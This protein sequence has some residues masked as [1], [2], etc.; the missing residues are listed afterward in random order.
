MLYVN[1][2]LMRLYA[3][4]W[5]VTRQ[6]IYERVCVETAAWVMREMQSPEGGYYSSLDADSEGHEGKF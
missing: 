3:D 5:C 4:A 1:G 2:W 6:P